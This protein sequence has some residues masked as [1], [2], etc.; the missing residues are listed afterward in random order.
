MA[1]VPWIK[2]SQGLANKIDPARIQYSPKEG[3]LHYAEAY[4]VD[5]DIT[6]AVSRRLGFIE[7]GVTAD[8]HSFFDAG[9]YCIIVSGTSLFLLAGDNSTKG[10]RSGLTPGKYMSY[11]QVGSN[12]IY[13]NGSES[14]IVRDGASWTYVKAVDS[15]YPDA[16][17]EYSDPP[18]GTI[19]R[20]FSGRTYIADGNTLWYSEP[21]SINLFR[22]AANYVSFPGKIVM[23][24]PVMGGL[25]VSTVSKIYFLSGRDPKKF[26][27]ITVS[28][29]PAIEGTDVEADGIALNAGKVSPLPVQ[30]FTTTQGICVGTSEGQMVNLTYD[31]LEYPKSLRGCA[32][33]TG[34][35]YIVSLEA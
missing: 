22:R 34:K 4:N 10:I 25:F 31:I 14:G 19:V 15:R 8:T 32:V 35:K 30:I 24:A 6:G 21:Y 2:H 1:T 33:Y 18:I 9:E 20:F 29:Y 26:E 5:F 17:R 7:T 3:V 28:H 16:T 27:L 11:C 23:V 13:M 12:V